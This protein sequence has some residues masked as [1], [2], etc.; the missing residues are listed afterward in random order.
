NITESP[1]VSEL[2]HLNGLPKVS[3]MILNYNGRNFLNR[4]LSSIE[5]LNYPADQFEVILVDNLSTDD[6]VEFMKLK[7]PGI[8]IVQLEKNYGFGGGNNRGLKYAKGE[9]LIFLN[10]DTQV[11][12]KWLL[13]LVE[14][15]RNHSA[16]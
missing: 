14:A 11:T 3:I 1:S 4:C 8:K 5:K 12:E 2:M 10:N 9:Y 15:S 13:A 6:S 7:Y 16:C